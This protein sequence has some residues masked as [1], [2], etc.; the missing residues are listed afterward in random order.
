MPQCNDLVWSANCN[1]QDELDLQAS[2]DSTTTEAVINLDLPVGTKIYNQAGEL[3]AEIEGEPDKCK[4]KIP[5][6]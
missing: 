6:N 3:I 5:A 1:E 4:I 2:N